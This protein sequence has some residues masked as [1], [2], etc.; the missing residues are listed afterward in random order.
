MLLA[1]LCWAADST[2]VPAQA[3]CPDPALSAN[4]AAPAASP[5]PGTPVI[6][7]LPATRDRK[8]AHRAFGRGLKLEK[9]QNLED[10]FD[11]F[12]E[13]ARLDPMNPEYLAAREMTRE[14]MAGVHLDRGNSALLAGH[15]A[16]AL[17][18]FRAALNLDPQN[19]FAQERLQEALGSP[20]ARTPGQVQLVDQSDSISLKRSSALTGLHDIHYRGD[21]NNLLTTVAASYGL[22]VVFDESFTNRRVRL[23]IDQA[24]FATAIRAACKVTKSFVVPIESTVL[25]AALD[26]PDNH[27]TFDRMGMRAFYVP[28]ATASDLNDITNALR[29][30]FEFKSINFNVPNSTITVRGPIPAVE[31]ATR[32]FGQL[33]ANQPEVL[34]D[35]QILEVSH[36]FAKDIGLHIP[37][38]FN[39]YNLPAAALASLG[40]QNIQSLITQLISSG[41]INQAG[42]STIA[43]LLAQLQGQGNSIFSQPLATFGGGLTLMGLTFD[44]LAA[45]F[46]LNESA[47]TSLQHVNL[48]A[49][50][51]K[52]ATLRL[53]SRYPVLNASFSPI[54]S[55]TAISGV[56]KN[57]TYTAPFPSVNYEDLGLTLKAKPSVNHESD[58]R[59]EVNVQFR[60]LGT[61]SLNGVP[62]IEQREYTGG[63]MLKDGETAAIAGVLTESDQRSLNGLPTF[64]R[65]PGFGTLVSN[66][67]HQEADDELL[68]VVTP[69]VLR[70]VDEEDPP[71]IWLTR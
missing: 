37:N 70:Q 19:E 32:F 71:A 26:N 59:L 55:S 1:G 38:Q 9:S 23:D 20:Q 33:N 3:T 15:Q 21:S 43:A 14:H 5:A 53:G 2:P 63:V 10:A 58:V 54:A 34:L 42:N 13:A 29:Q 18:E 51:G 49:T 60:S 61:G 11:Q 56:L 36:T 24:D 52:E 22:T 6:T 40:G 4:C 62:V 45:A 50:Q 41:G 48:R 7:S 64:A 68:I 46:S 16:D 57:Q 25:F 27:R 39:L 35:V 47:V 12:E 8:S 28:N 66:H 67:S 17:T 31:A 44:R 69:H 65:V 30:T